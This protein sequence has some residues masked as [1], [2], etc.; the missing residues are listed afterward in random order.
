MTLSGGATPRP[1][2]HLV[3]LGMMGAGKTTTG[4]AVAARLDRPLR[5][6][7]D[8]LEARTGRTG[9]EIAATDGVDHLH[10]LEE[11]VLLDALASD[12]PAVITGAGWVVESERCRV[13]LADAVVVWLDAPVTELADRMAAS[14]HRRPM[15]PADAE[16]VL[17]RRRARFAELADLHLDARAPTDELVAAIVEA[18]ADPTRVEQRRST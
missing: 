10:H 7:D 15:D 5:D 1:A 14:G 13:A 9:A 16:A 8:D 12:P 11:T 17:T 3:L 18:A 2:A 6:C 4:R